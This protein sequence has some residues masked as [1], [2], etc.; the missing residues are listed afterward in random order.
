MW[1]EGLRGSKLLV[2]QSFKYILLGL[3]TL[4]LFERFMTL[5]STKETFM[6]A[7]Y[8]KRI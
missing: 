1:T 5:I 6:F 4:D 8:S 7:A 2:S 3:N